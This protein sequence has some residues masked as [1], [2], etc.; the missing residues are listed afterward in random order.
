M[1]N[2]FFKNS[3][4]FTLIELLAVIVILALIMS[5]AVF[6]MSGVLDSAK[7]NTAKRTASSYIDAARKQLLTTN[8]LEEGTFFIQNALMESGGVTSPLGGNYL[9]ATPSGT[10]LV[11]GSAN[12]TL[13]APGIYKVTSGTLPTCSATAYS[14]ITITKNVYTGGYNYAY[15]ICLAAGTGNKYISGTEAQLLDDSNTSVIVT[16]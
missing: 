4:G 3:K 8:K 10:P 9:F 6:S 16:P 2:N 15:S 13:V 5:I 14:F 12:V 1:R 11:V 7:N